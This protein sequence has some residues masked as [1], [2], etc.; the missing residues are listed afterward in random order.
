LRLDTLVEQIE[1]AFGETPP[2]TSEGLAASDR[3]VLLRVFGDEGYQLYLQDQVNRQI[4]RD[5]LT[6]AVMLG[7]IP[8]HDLVGF[9]PMIESKDARAALSLHML[10]SS[11]EQAPELLLRGVP[12]AL[13]QLKPD[14]DSPPHIRLIRS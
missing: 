11:V 8:E 14:A 5:Y 10:M 3:E 13:E 2:F 9:N 6:N 12:G 4:I 7:F 1:T